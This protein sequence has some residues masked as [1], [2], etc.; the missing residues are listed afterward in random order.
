[1]TSNLSKIS[2]FLSRNW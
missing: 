2:K 1:M